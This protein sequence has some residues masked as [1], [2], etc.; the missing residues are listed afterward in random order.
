MKT[1]HTLQTGHIR[2]VHTINQQMTQGTL[3]RKNMDPC[4]HAA[5]TSLAALMILAVIG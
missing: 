4:R 5:V 2:N 1:K 3:K